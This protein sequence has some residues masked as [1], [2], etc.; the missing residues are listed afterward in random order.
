MLGVST[1]GYYAW[2]RRPPSRQAQ[3]NRALSREIAQIHEQSRGTYGVSTKFRTI[4]AVAAMA[5]EWSR[6]S[7]DLAQDWR[8]IHVD[9]IGLVADYRNRS[10]NTFSANLWNRSRVKS[11]ASSAHTTGRWS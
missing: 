4:W 7:I 9:L 3:A 10:K 2:R 11:P 5:V 1:S 8:G 6:R